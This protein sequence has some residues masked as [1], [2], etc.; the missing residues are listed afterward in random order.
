MKKQY[1]KVGDLVTCAMFGKGEVVNVNKQGSIRV[2]FEQGNLLDYSFDGKLSSETKRTLYQGHF[3]ILEPI[4][5]E[6]VTFEKD[7]IVWGM[8]QYNRWHCVK[9]EEFIPNSSARILASH[10]QED[11]VYC[12][13]EYYDIRKY[14]DRPF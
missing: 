1:F 7:E 4:L 12:A 8:D 2:L 11:S 14:E 9:F 10:P 6:I 13:K 5:K 3:D